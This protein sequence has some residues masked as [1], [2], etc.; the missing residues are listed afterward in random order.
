VVKTFNFGDLEETAFGETANKN[1]NNYMNSNMGW[2]NQ[3]PEKNKNA[4]M[5]IYEKREKSQ[6]KINISAEIVQ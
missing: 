4:Y 6:F 1:K 5:L 3:P 2:D